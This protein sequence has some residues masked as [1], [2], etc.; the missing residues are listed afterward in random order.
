L[1]FQSREIT[2]LLQNNQNSLKKKRISLNV[3]EAITNIKPKKEIFQSTHILKNRLQ[4]N[5]GW[6]R[7]ILSMIISKKRK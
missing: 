6:R 5:M 3:A 2:A 1:I 7:F 4:M